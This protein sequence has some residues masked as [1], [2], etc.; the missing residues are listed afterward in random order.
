MT[1]H[2][3]TWL[4]R[5][6]DR[7]DETKLV[8]AVF[9]G[10]L[11]GV[12]ATLVIDY[13]ELQRMQAY[14]TPVSSRPAP[15]LP[16]ADPQQ[17]QSIEHLRRPDYVT[18][19][20]ETH[21]SSMRIELKGDGV[22]SLVGTIDVGTAKKFASRLKEIGEYVTTVRL[23][24]PGGSL[25]DALSMG[26]EIRQRGYNTRVSAGSLCASACPLVFA[27]GAERQ[28]EKQAAFGLHQVYTSGKTLISPAQAL[29][30]AQRT[31]ARIT[32]YLE[33]MGVD[34]KVWNFALETPPAR[35]YYLS[36]EQLAEFQ[37]TNG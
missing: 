9:F 14:E 3:R 21:R 27:G 5:L 17:D 23:D 12:I 24:S 2:H 33:E 37:V 30:S 7:Y 4:Q 6:W 18:T 29:S 25:S 10:M 36:E 16:A 22:L 11:T 32:R 8:K 20:A 13:Q 31:T 19:P 34:P 15:I 26:A 1:A 28:V 35:L